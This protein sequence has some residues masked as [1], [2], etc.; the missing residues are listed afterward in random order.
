MYIIFILPFSITLLSKIIIK[1]DMMNETRVSL[2]TIRK[3]SFV[4]IVYT[5][6]N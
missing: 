4:I 3:N 6:L 2:K 5:I 1:Y